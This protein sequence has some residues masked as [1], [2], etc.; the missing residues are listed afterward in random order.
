LSLAG[1]AA[2]TVPVKD[3]SNPAV[4]RNVM[5]FLTKSLQLSWSA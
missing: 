5:S 1:G 2:T 3:R 4:L